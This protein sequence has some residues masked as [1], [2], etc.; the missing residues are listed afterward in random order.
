MQLDQALQSSDITSQTRTSQRDMLIPTM[1]AL[2]GLLTLAW[3]GFLGW[4]ALSLV[5]YLFS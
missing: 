5:S 2:G 3:T 4:G 1:L